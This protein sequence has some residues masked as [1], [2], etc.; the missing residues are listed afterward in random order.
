MKKVTFLMLTLLIVFTT[1]PY[2]LAFGVSSDDIAVSEDVMCALNASSKCSCQ[3]DGQCATSHN[4]T[5]TARKCSNPKSA[6]SA[7][8]SFGRDGDKE[9]ALNG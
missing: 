2:V 1:C 8:L 4:C 3:T 6:P 5:Y 7:N 9:I